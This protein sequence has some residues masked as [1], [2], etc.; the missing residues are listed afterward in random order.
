MVEVFHRIRL[1]IWKIII[2]VKSPRQDCPG[3]FY[4]SASSKRIEFGEV[5][6]TLSS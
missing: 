4:F 5:R 1:T 2:I 6:K 3:L